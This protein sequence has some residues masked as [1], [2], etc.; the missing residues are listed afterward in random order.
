MISQS[1]ANHLYMKTVIKWAVQDSFFFQNQHDSCPKS[2]SGI[3]AQ[4]IKMNEAV[5]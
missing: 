4:S 2:V 1:K 3:E 5:L